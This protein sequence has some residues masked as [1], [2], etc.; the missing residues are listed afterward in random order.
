MQYDATESLPPAPP[1]GPARPAAQ[2][3]AAVALRT[4]PDLLAADA[5]I[6]DGD[7]DLARERAYHALNRAKAAGQTLLEAQALASLAHYDRL[8][9]RVRRAAEASARAALLFKSVGELADEAIAH[10]SHANA[11][12]VLGRA[13]EA[14]EA[15]QLSVE[16][17]RLTPPGVHSVLA[18]NALGIALGWSGN[19]EAAFD[20]F[21][22]GSEVARR[23]QPALPDYQLAANRA[24]A[25]ALRLMAEREAGRDVASERLQR[26]RELVQRFRVCEA[27]GRAQALLEG[28]ERPLRALASLIEGLLH[29]W[30]GDLAAAAAALAATRR[31]LET[32]TFTSWI[33]AAVCWVEAEL[34]WAAGDAGLAHDWLRRLCVCANEVEHEQL[35]CLSHQLASQFHARRGEHGLALQAL[36][37][38]RE[39]ELANRRESLLG[40]T[41][42]VQWQL[43]ARRAQADLGVLQAESRLLERLSYEDTLTGIANRRRFEAHLAERLDAAASLRQPLALALLDIDDFKRINDA[44]GHDAGDLVLRRLARLLGSELRESDL[45]ARL[46]GDEFVI[47]FDRTELAQAQQIC[48]RIVHAVATLDWSPLCGSKAMAVSIGAAQALPGDTGVALL[49]RA[50]RA[51]YQS[52]RPQR[53]GA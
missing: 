24:W 46:G 18:H 53:H 12:I 26:L 39:R 31:W 27:T 44:C 42:S 35:A 6:A 2:R 51:M 13:E 45:A 41:Q 16:L 23:C 30:A 37:A 40:R 48:D 14:V 29:A 38:L 10:T 21:D 49:R 50:D 4:D 52:K 9:S 5:A 17:A 25:E 11:A 22:A 47:V 8:S 28:F 34:A 32:I 20:A 19:F 36:R 43:E 1:P 15:A 33:D 7:A 3:A